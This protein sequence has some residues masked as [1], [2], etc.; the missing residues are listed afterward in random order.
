MQQI[1]APVTQSSAATGINNLGNVVGTTQVTGPDLAWLWTGGESVSDLD[2][3][4]DA[5]AEN[6]TTIA[7]HDINDAGQIL[8]LGFDNNVSEFRT[9]VLTPLP[10]PGQSL[11]LGSGIGFLGVLYRRRVR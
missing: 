9:V 3:L 5:V 6:I 10:E 11:M 8:A 4:F 7:A 1:P 2:D